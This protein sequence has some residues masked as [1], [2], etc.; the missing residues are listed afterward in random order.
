MRFPVGN[1]LNGDMLR[2]RFQDVAAIR[3]KEPAM[4]QTDRS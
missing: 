3:K 2:I 1:S 4:M